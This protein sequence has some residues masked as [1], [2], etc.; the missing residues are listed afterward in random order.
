M[1]ILDPTENYL[2]IDNKRI[3]SITIKQVIASVQIRYNLFTSVQKNY[4]TAN[5]EF[6]RFAHS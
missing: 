3:L 6:V 5:V 1:T 2:H 4:T